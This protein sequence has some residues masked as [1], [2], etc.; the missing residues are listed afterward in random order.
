MTL[1]DVADHVAALLGATSSS[2]VAGP[3]STPRAP[4]GTQSASDAAAD[5]STEASPDADV[6][7]ALDRGSVAEAIALLIP[8][9]RR[10][11][12]PSDRERIVALLARAAS[13][14]GASVD[15]TTAVAPLV[16]VLLTLRA[17]ARADKRWSDSDT[18]RD[19]LAAAG[20]DVRDTPGGTEWEVRR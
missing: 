9:V 11:E 6:L 14:D 2:G 13:L 15:R 19:G 20:I 17:Q 12:D 18:I 7:D 3:A 5:I 8:S 4:V 10:A 16:E 1:D